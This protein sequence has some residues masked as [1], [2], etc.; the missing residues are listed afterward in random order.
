MRFMPDDL[1]RSLPERPGSLR[2]LCLGL[3]AAGA[4]NLG[5][6][7]RTAQLT[8]DYTALGVT[9]PPVLGVI[10]GLGWGAGFL[11]SAWR[12]WR[13]RSGSPRQV[14]IL[15]VGH[16]LYQLAW[17]RVF[18]RSDYAV[19]RWPFEALTAVLLAALVAWILNR[20]RVRAL[21]RSNFADRHPRE[22]S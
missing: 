6:A 5:A 11:W 2:W 3:A 15:V 4:I 1:P 8:P 7:V 10:A 20:P 18:A 9:F 19:D 16:S 12:L 13:L 17:M 14:L 21:F 22:T